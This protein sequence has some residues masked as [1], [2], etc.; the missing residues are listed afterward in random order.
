MDTINQNRRFMFCP[1]FFEGMK[2][3]DQAKKIPA[4]AF[5]KTIVGEVIKLPSFEGLT[6]ATYADLLDSRRSKRNYTNTPMTQE[7]LAFMLWSTQGIQYTR[8]DVATF[9]PVPSGGARHPFETYITV[10]NVEGLKAGLYHYLPT[11][12]IGEKLVTIE[13]L[14]EIDDYDKKITSALA[15]QAWATT[16]PI[17]MF[18]TCI[19]YKAE[20]RYHE[21][22][23]RVMLIDLG[24]LGQN[25]MLS[26]V[27]LGLGSCCMAAYNQAECDKLLGLKDL[28]EYTVYAVSVGTPTEYTT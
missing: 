14:G 16:A 2:E 17:I 23:H 4:P 11:E 9:R 25:A 5:G 28:D 20:W 7:Q 24:H 13:Y 6:T 19:P 3:S 26:A 18:T 1:S 12:N 27:A 15:E 8:K 21:M 22:S 10:K